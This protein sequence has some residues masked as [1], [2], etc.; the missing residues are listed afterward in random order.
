MDRQ[1]ITPEAMI[2]SLRHSFEIT[3]DPLKAI[4]SI[5]RRV[6]K[7]PTGTLRI[8]HDGTYVSFYERIDKKKAYLK[9]GSDRVYLLARKRYLNELLETLIVV[10]EEGAG[11]QGFAERFGKLTELIEDF[12]KEYS[13]SQVGGI[14]DD[15]VKMK[16]LKEY[17]IQAK[18]NLR[19]GK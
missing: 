18:Y 17:L 3:N 19:G 15:L 13:L 14:T 1:F 2:R 7:L 11:S 10:K 6:S 16:F 4:S 9:K 8:L 12:C 5:R